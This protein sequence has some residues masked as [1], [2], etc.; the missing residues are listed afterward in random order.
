MED[1]KKKVMS[2]YLRAGGTGY[3]YTHCQALCLLE[4]SEMTRL[5]LPA[6]FGSESSGRVS[7]GKMPSNKVWSGIVLSRNV[8]EP[9]GKHAPV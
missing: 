7:S 2:F 5:L 8:L 6:T 9:L 3:L 1:G 4:S